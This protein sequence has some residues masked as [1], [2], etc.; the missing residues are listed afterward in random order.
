[1]RKFIAALAVTVAV[2]A[3][4]AVSGDA[5]AAAKHC[6]HHSTGKCKANSKHPRGAIAKCKDGTYSR[7]KH[8]A[9][10]CSHHK[11]VKYWYK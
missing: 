5:V 8:F 7:S 9:G 11:G 4:V 1:M 2:L 6:A 10:A 3:P